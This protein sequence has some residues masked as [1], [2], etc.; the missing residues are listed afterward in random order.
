MPF[1]KA[2]C[3]LALCLTLPP[4]VLAFDLVK[5]T[6]LVSLRW[7][8]CENGYETSG[9]GGDYYFTGCEQERYKIWDRALGRVYSELITA[10]PSR[11]GL[12]LKKSQRIWLTYRD[13]DAA[14]FMASVEVR[15]GNS[16]SDATRKTQ[17]VQNRV[18][19]LASLLQDVKEE[20]NVCPPPSDVQNAAG[21]APAQSNPLGR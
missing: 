7:K 4:P 18:E 1:K 12:Q 8:I 10:L 3:W 9:R 16:H 6:E 5:T 19:L 21:A 15:P 17:R 20:P 11:C 14:A 2:S 13:A